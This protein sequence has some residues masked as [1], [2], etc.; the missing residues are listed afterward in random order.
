MPAQCRDDAADGTSDTGLP[1]FRRE[2]GAAIRS[3]CRSFVE[4]CRGLKLLSGEM[5][6]IDGSKLKAVKSHGRHSTAGKIDKRQQHIEESVQR[7]LDLIETADRTSTTSLDAKTVRLYEK[8]A[9]LRWK[10]RELEEVKKQSQK[11]PDRKLASPIPAGVRAI[12]LRGGSTCRVNVDTRPKASK[13]E[14][15]SKK[16][17]AKSKKQKDTSMSGG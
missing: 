6:A 16:Q 7:Y 17:K 15:K 11:Q 5:V 3:V 14:A 2:N 4:L 8:I 9:R 10:M 1:D 12:W 13:Q